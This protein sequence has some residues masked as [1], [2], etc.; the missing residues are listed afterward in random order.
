M[1]AMVLLV[2]KT[3]FN[4]CTSWE[5]GEGVGVG[6]GGGVRGGWA[7]V[8]TPGLRLNYLVS[9]RKLL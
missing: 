6:V 7:G 8:G 4:Q 1:Q 2:L 9:P 5:G 3:L